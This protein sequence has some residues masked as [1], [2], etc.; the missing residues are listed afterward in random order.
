MKNILKVICFLILT[1]SALYG[2]TV[3]NFPFNFGESGITEGV[4]DIEVLDNGDYIA[5]FYYDGDSTGIAYFD[6]YGHLHWQTKVALLGHDGVKHYHKQVAMT[7]D[8]LLVF[9]ETLQ[10][11]SFFPEVSSW[12][13]KMYV[14]IFSNDGELLSSFEPQSDFEYISLG[15]LEVNDADELLILGLGM[16][17]NQVGS[18]DN[19]LIKTDL[20]GLTINEFSIRDT[21][22]RTE[23]EE[24]DILSTGEILIGTSIHSSVVG[25]EGYKIYYLN[26]DFEIIWSKEFNNS[27]RHK[28]TCE[29]QDGNILLST[30]YYYGLSPQR[31]IL[32][33]DKTTG[34]T[35]HQ[36][37]YAAAGDDIDRSYNLCTIEQP[38]GTFLSG[39]YLWTEEGISFAYVMKLDSAFNMLWEKRYKCLADQPEEYIRDVEPT[40]DGGLLLGGWTRGFEPENEEIWLLKVDSLGNEY[41]PLNAFFEQDTLEIDLYESITLNPIPYGGSNTYTHQWSGATEFLNDT[42]IWCPEFSGSELGVFELNYEV[43]DS[44]NELASASIFVKVNDIETTSETGVEHEVLVY[45]NP[46]KDILNIEASNYPYILRITDMKGRLV[47]EQQVTTTNQQIAINNLYPNQ[48]YVYE[49]FFDSGE[50]QKG[51]FLKLR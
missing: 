19:I 50:F 15:Y 28:Y 30:L 46:A 17:L 12:R 2:Q 8:S 7:S 23:G 26:E 33:L 51:K 44:E 25:F 41:L 39:G 5:S 4:Q 45:P 47:K 42:D 14:H 27:Y 35:I 40:P 34:E 16:D 22:Y 9:L 29:T 49:L 20:E 36:E 21:I 43:T 48:I 31:A 11:D 3:Y 6:K 37:I 13:T 1:Q 38:D 10:S 18:F 24:I 32:K